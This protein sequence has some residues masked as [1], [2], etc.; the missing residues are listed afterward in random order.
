MKT[1]NVLFAGGGTGGHLTP[2]LA[3]AVELRRRCPGA[4]VL[5]V[6]TAK[7]LERKLVERAGFPYAAVQSRPP[8][9]SAW[10]LPA[11]ALAM[12][13]V[14]R[15]TRQATGPFGADLTVGLG[16]YGCAGAALSAILRRRPLMLLEQNV[17]PGRATRLF[18]RWSDLVCC[19]F[20]EA[21]PRLRGSGAMCTGNP[22][23][24]EIGRCDRGEGARRLGLDASRRTLLVM[25]GSQGALAL[26]EA[27]IAV[28]PALAARRP[29]LQVVHLAGRHKLREVRHAY[30]A[31]GI[32]AVV[33]ELLEDMPA[34]YAAADLVVSRAGATSLAELAA[35]ALPSVLVPYP[36]A[37]DDHQT[38]NAAPYVERNAAIMVHQRELTAKRLARL[39]LPLLWDDAR[40]ATMRDGARSLATPR[41]AA[42]VVDQLL[43]IAGQ[44]KLHTLG[45]TAAL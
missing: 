21:I 39:L 27:M 2:G 11:T 43:E 18:A 5:F 4:G 12:L 24:P 9:R 42:T 29:P 14:A 25:G 31:A 36:H 19:Q 3:V 22:V 23:R 6:G 17:I 28:A 1:L 45:Q 32:R 10:A 7:E 35:A 38:Y 8:S 15:Q 41:A 34:A 33:A 30:E 44:R 13:R 37:T 16:G 26:N 20:A 40:L